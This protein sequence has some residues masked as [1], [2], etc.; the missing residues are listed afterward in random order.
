MHSASI[1]QIPVL[2]LEDGYD[3]EHVLARDLRGASSSNTLNNPIS[4]TAK[5]SARRATRSRRLKFVVVAVA[6]LLAVAGVHAYA[7]QIHPEALAAP[8]RDAGWV[9]VGLYV[10]GFC[11][12][13]LF[14]VPGILFVFTGVMVY[15]KFYGWLLAVTTAPISVSASFLVVRAIGGQPLKDNTSGWIHKL[16]G[17]L[18]ERP[19]TTVVVLRLLT[20]LAP[21]VNYALALT[22]V[23]FS[24]FFI[25]SAIGLFL[26]LTFVVVLIENFIRIWG[27]DV[28]IAPPPPMLEHMMPII[29]TTSDTLADIAP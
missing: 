23:P 27:Y 6:L 29:S 8:L 24:T 4:P 7:P 28:V 19:M 13:E 20:F 22:S 17:H 11:L 25:A 5:K 10:I 2:Q 15:G 1:H 16:L 9:G 21:G 3:R 18:E 12:G 26:P 14:H